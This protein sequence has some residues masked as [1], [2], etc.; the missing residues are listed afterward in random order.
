MEDVE[1]EC[2]RGFLSLHCSENWFV[3]LHDIVSAEVRIREVV[4]CPIEEIRHIHIGVK[5]V[6]PEQS[7]IRDRL[8]LLGCATVA[9]VVVTVLAIGVGTIVG[10][11]R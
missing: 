11:L 8:A 9:I 5:R 3:R 1:I 6:A 4:A 10:W 7:R 2:E